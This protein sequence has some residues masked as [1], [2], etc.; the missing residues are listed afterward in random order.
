MLH[1]QQ[2]AAEVA[3]R[4]AAEKDDAVAAARLEREAAAVSVAQ[5]E[6]A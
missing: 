2:E 4:V 5:R 6:A 1:A 3:E